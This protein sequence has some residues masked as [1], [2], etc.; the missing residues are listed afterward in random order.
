MATGEKKDGDSSPTV[1]GNAM[2]ARKKGELVILFLASLTGGG[3]TLHKSNAFSGISLAIGSCIQIL[4][5]VASSRLLR[6]IYKF[7]ST[8]SFAVRR[9]SNA[10]ESVWEFHSK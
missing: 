10:R 5:I 8:S 2:A 6:Q 4:F 7:A 1:T 9:C 3:Q